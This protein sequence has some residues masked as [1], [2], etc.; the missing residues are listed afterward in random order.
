VNLSRAII[1]LS[2]VA[3]VPGLLVGALAMDQIGSEPRRETV[4]INAYPWASIGKIGIAGVA[5]R[6]SCTGSVIGPKQFLTAAHCLYS[7]TTGHFVSASEIHFLLGYSK[8]EYRAHRVGSG[9][10]TSPKFNPEKTETAGNDWA[11]VSIDEPFPPDTKPLR[12]AAETPKP[13][14]PVKTGGYPTEKAHM[15]TADKHCHVKKV[16]TDGKLIT[17]DCIV[18]HG[19]SGGPLLSED[20]AEGLIWGVNSLGFSPL[21]ELKDQAKGGSAAA[22]AWAI[23]QSLASQGSDGGDGRQ[24]APMRSNP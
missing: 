21:V 7:K 5:L 24:R 17:D 2:L 3:A 1:L 8:G 19:D 10:I 11:V 16:S 4:D 20:D 22:A 18:H 9:Y 23:Q 6:T 13:D 14:T 15:M 12:L